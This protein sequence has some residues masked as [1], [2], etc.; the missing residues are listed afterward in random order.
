M[1]CLSSATRFGR[2]RHTRKQRYLAI[3]SGIFLPTLLFASVTAE[4]AVYLLGAMGAALVFL[5]SVKYLIVNRLF[6]ID[7]KKLLYFHLIGLIEMLVVLLIVD[8]HDDV[9]IPVY[10]V[11]AL[12]INLLYFPRTAYRP[13]LRFA[14]KLF[15]LTLTT[16]L[17][18]FAVLMIAAAVST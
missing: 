11:S 3:L 6:K 7:R 13:E 1:R 5:P 4:G 10:F 8:L 9:L 14:L 17:F 16:P 18:L 15:L 2:N 12:I